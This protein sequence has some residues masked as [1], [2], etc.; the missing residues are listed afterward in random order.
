[1]SGTF[2][3][4]SLSDPKNFP[5]K[6]G[7][8]NWHVKDKNGIQAWKKVIFTDTEAPKGKNIFKWDLKHVGGNLEKQLDNAFGKGFY[9]KKIQSYIEAAKDADY[10]FQEGKNKGKNL[11]TILRDKAILLDYNEQI[12]KG[13]KLPDFETYRGN[14][15]RGAFSLSEVHHPFGISIDPYTTEP[16][17][18]WANRQERA[19]LSKYKAGNITFDEF[20]KVMEDKLLN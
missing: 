20:K 8:V 13:R 19:E 1:M 5:K 11:K 17:T 4:K 14:K 10:V 7:R 18:R 15:L 16:A 3:G 9:N 6:D 12:K 2:N